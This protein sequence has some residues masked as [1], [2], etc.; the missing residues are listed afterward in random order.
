MSFIIGQPSGGGGGGGANFAVPLTITNFSDSAA[1]NTAMGSYSN[2]AYYTS[3]RIDGTT[4]IKN[5]GLKVHALSATAGARMYGSLYKYNISTNDLELIA[6]MPTEIDVDSATGVSGWQFV[7]YSQP[8]VLES[9][10]YFSRL[11]C[12]ATFQIGVPNTTYMNDTMG[13]EGIGT[14]TNFVYGFITLSVPYDFGSTPT[15]IPFTDL[16]IGTNNSYAVASG[17]F[18]T[19]TN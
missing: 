7:N 3:F 5:Q 1:V 6:V 8:I 4:T 10:I 19:I 2:R 13:V 18:Y 14:S 15:S 11:I 16:T 12:N 17:L 9:G